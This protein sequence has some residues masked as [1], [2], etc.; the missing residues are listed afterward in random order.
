MRPKI[1]TRSETEADVGAINGVTVAAFKAL[2]I[3]HHTEQFIIAAL[4]I[5]D[6][7]LRA[8]G[9]QERQARL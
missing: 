3:S 5:A 4:R 9:Q 7:A 2:E 6:E 1:V 8:D